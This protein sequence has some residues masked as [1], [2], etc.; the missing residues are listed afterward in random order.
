[1]VEVEVEVELEAIHFVENPLVGFPPPLHLSGRV[2][3]CPDS[4]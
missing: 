4:H 1:M 2:H 3:A